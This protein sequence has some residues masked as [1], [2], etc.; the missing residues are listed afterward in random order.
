[1]S[2]IYPRMAFLTSDVIVFVTRDAP[3]S[4]E[5]VTKLRRFFERSTRGAARELP[6]MILVFNYAK[7]KSAYTEKED[8]EFTQEFLRGHGGTAVEDCYNTFDAFRLWTLPEPEWETDGWDPE[9]EVTEQDHKK[10]KKKRD[11]FDARMQQLRDLILKRLAGR[12]EYRQACGTAFQHKLWI[13]IFLGV[14]NDM[15]ADSKKPIFM[16]QVISREVIQASQTD[17]RS[18]RLLAEAELC[19]D[20]LIAHCHGAGSS[21]CSLASLWLDS[22]E[23]VVYLLTSAFA[24]ILYCRA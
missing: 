10:F 11:R 3:A 13:P 22:F 9:D 18:L 8:A 6:S 7:E 24:R 15:E 12:V 23:C 14:A 2:D 21:W 20:A 19:M 1:M 16:S 5:A 17:N 4:I